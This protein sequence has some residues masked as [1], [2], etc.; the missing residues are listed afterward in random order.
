MSDEKAPIDPPP[1][2]DNPLPIS[3]KSNGAG[4]PPRGP[5]PPF[6]LD[7]PALNMIRGKRVILASASP[8]RRQLLAQVSRI[9]RSKTDYPKPPQSNTRLSRSASQTS[10][11]SPPP[12]PKT[13]PTPFPPSNTSS[14][15][16]QP[17]PKTST[18]P[19]STPPTTSPPSSSPPT[20]SSPRTSAKSSR[21]RAASASTSQR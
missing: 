7:L 3:E 21:N 8:R 20:P 18:P 19:P 2:T 11:S 10:K 17:K 12:S 15:P 4:G 13:N 6:P 14:Q 5:R 9:A 16:P 1:Y